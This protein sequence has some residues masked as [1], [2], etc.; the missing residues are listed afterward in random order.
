MLEK[1]ITKNKF[2]Q[3]TNP[4]IYIYNIVHKNLATTS[5]PTHL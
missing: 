5:L 3:V 2:L 1:N 4:Y